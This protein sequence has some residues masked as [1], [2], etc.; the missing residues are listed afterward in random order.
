MPRVL[1]VIEFESK[2]DLAEVKKIAADMG[3]PTHGT[4]RDIA[5]RILKYREAQQAKPPQPKPPQQEA[6]YHVSQAVR[7]QTGF[8]WREVKGIFVGG[9]VERGVGSSFR[10]KAHA[11]CFRKDPYFGWICV[12]SAKRLG[13]VSGQEVTKPSALLWHEYAHILTPDHYHDDYWR[14]TMKVLGQPIPEQ[15]QRKR[16]TK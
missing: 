13:E 4:K 8:D 5:L 15:Y 12:R 1:E 9:C 14:G 3:L 6:I 10:A 11:H 7:K 2:H 16:R